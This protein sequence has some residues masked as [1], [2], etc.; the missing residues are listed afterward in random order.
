[1]SYLIALKGA[2]TTLKTST[3]SPDT[4]SLRARTSVRA[5]EFWR[6]SWESRSPKFNSYSNSLAV[7]S[8]G[9]NKKIKLI[10]HQLMS[11]C[12]SASNIRR[13]HCHQLSSGQYLARSLSFDL[14]FMHFFYGFELRTELSNLIILGNS[15][16]SLQLSIS[17]CL[18]SA[19]YLLL[20]RQCLLLS[21]T[22]IPS[23]MLVLLPLGV[24]ERVRTDLW[25]PEDEGAT[26]DKVTSSLSSS[27]SR[28][29]HS[30]TAP[31]ESLMGL[32][33]G[34]PWIGYS[35][36]ISFIPSFP[37]TDNWYLKFKLNWNLKSKI[38]I[39]IIKQYMSQCLA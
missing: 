26:P 30:T 32:D 12:E 31:C 7:A 11:M 35:H 3:T 9:N 22:T 24:M 6:F 36:L 2:N 33:S 28:A 20:L 16:V 38:M 1:M 27:L 21:P 10:R 4:S 19:S 29:L 34:I 25:G 5:T 8:A 13:P 15:G 39:K 14:K 23:E 37:V 17:S 18:G